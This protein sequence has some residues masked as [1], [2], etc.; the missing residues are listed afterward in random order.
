L[1][2]DKMRARIGRG[3]D[4]NLARASDAPN[5]VPTRSRDRFPGRG[6]DGGGA[7]RNLVRRARGE[8]DVAAVDATV[9]LAARDPTV[10]RLIK[11]KGLEPKGTRPAKRPVIIRQ[12]R[13]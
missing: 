5:V 12:I 1:Y 9:D 11:R 7:D 8:V 2:D 13:R 3:S 6:V 10:T 4:R